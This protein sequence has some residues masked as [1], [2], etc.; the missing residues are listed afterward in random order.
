MVDRRGKRNPAFAG[1]VGAGFVARPAVFHS[2]VATA[3]L[4]RAAACSNHADSSGQA[5]PRQVSEPR[6]NSAAIKLEPQRTQGF[7]E[8]QHR[9]FALWLFPCVLCVPCG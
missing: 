3:G 6:C 1:T 2:V 4:E 8:E 9:G 7:T 5:E